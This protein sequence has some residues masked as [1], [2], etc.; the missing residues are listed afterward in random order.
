VFIRAASVNSTAVWA[1]APNNIFATTSGNAAMAI[2]SDAVPE[3]AL[4]VP[5]ASAFHRG[6]DGVT[7]N[8]SSLA[9]VL[10]PAQNV[11]ANLLANGSFETG[12][13]TATGWE[14]EGTAPRLPTM[15]R[16]ATGTVDGG[17]AQRLQF[18]GRVGDSGNVAIYQAPIACTPGETFRASIYLS[19]ALTN[20]YAIWG[21]EGFVTP[22]GAYISEHD[23]VINAGQLT[24]APALYTVEY[25]APADCTALAVYFQVP[26]LAPTSIVDVYLDRAVLLRV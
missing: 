26:S 23:T 21:I 9:F 2:R 24:A 4:S 19:G 12:G 22:G 15:S 17:V 1:T 11:V 20:A 16:V 6:N 14:I 18:T 8:E 3:G 25:T 7:R 10:Q 5:P 13:N